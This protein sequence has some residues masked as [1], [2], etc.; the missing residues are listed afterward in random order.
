MRLLRFNYMETMK[1]ILVAAA[2]VLLTALAMFAADGAKIEFEQT[3][4]DFG[5][6]AAN[7][8]PVKMEYK[9]TN[10]GKS[11][12]VIVTV[13][14]GG[15][16][17][18]KPSFPKAPIQPGKSGVIT[19]SFNPEGRSGSVNRE[20]KVRTNADKKTVKLKFKGTV[21]PRK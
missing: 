11:P 18:T 21:I 5:R 7:Q 20:V 3:T 9:F 12:L 4:V 15:C 14:N 8:G 2:I 13:T 1:K 17:C 16:G 6:V 19:I 10:T